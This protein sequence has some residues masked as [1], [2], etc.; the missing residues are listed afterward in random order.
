MNNTQLLGNAVHLYQ[1]AKTMSI[2]L[3]QPLTPLEDYFGGVLE[4][5]LENVAIDMYAKEPL[6]CERVRE[7][8]ASRG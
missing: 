1:A 8:K 7:V 5:A 4:Q 6:F 2:K 3:K